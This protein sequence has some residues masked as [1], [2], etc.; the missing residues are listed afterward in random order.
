MR[1]ILAVSTFFFLAAQWRPAMD[2][3]IPVFADSFDTPLTFAENWAAYGNAVSGDGVLRLD[4]A[5]ATLRKKIPDNFTVKVDVALLDSD[6]PDNR[7]HAGLNIAEVRF[8][9]RPDGKAWLVYRLP[10]ETNARGSIRNIP[11]FKF[12]KNYTIT[13]Q[14]K[15]A[16]EERVFVFMLDGEDVGIAKMPLTAEAPVSLTTYRETALFDNFTLYE[17]E[18]RENPSPNV[19]VN[20]SFAH[21]QEGMPLYF[22]TQTL[23]KGSYKTTHE[24]FL[25]TF[26]V[27]TEEKRGGEQS[28][29][30]IFDDSCHS[31]GFLT[32]P[33]EMPVGK[34]LTFSAWLKSSEDDFPVTLLLYEAWEKTHSKEITVGRD[35]ARYS[36]TLDDPRRSTIRCGLRFLRPG[37][38]WVDEI[39]AESAPEPTPYRPSDLDDIKFRGETAARNRETREF[40]VGRL[41]KAPAAPEDLD[42]WKDGATKAETFH[43]ANGPAKAQSAAWLACDDAHLYIG[44]RAWV[45]DFGAIKAAGHPHDSFDAFNMDN[46]EIM[47]D[48]GRTRKTYF[49]LVVSAGGGRVDFGPGRAVAWDGDWQAAARLNPKEKSIDYG[50]KIPFGLLAGPMIDGDWGLNIGRTDSRTGEI[51]CLM[52]VNQPSF[53]MVQGYPVMKFPPEVLKRFALGIVDAGLAQSP[54]GRRMLSLSLDNNT[55]VPVSGAI[56]LARAENAAALGERIVAL[57]NGVNDIRFEMPPDIADPFAFYATFRS[58]ESSMLEQKVLPRRISP[59]TF[60][61]KYSYYMDDAQALFRVVCPLD[62]PEEYA[63]RLE[64]DGK[65]YPF[66]MA[67]EV[68][69]PVPLAD[70]SPGTHTAT[71]IIEKDG[72]VVVRESEP[73][74]KRPFRKGAARVNRFGRFVVMDDKPVLPVMPLVQGG[75]SPRAAHADVIDRLADSGFR[76]V[77]LIPRRGDREEALGLL[78][79][80]RERG[81]LVSYW[82]QFHWYADDEAVKSDVGM[83]NGFDNVFSQLVIDEPELYKTSEDAFAFIEKTRPYFPYQPVFMNNTILGIPNRFANLNTEILMLDDYITNREYR[84][85][86]EMIDQADIMWKAGEA[87]RR[88]FYFFLTGNN[89]HNHYREPTYAEQIAQTY[90]SL[91]AGCTGFAYFLGFASYPENWRAMK[92]L[93]RELNFLADV[94]LTDRETTPARVSDATIRHMTRLKGDDLYIIAVNA[95]D[96]PS[97]SVV[98]SLPD[99]RDYGEEVEALFDGRSI[100]LR[101]NQFS[102]SFPPLSRRVYRAAIRQAGAP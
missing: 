70:V 20:S 66:T 102:D 89:Q 90:G 101:G 79:R 62:H 55:G 33:S 75:E 3:G 6:D 31:Q 54:D 27:D 40:A 53:H 43:S 77:M 57:A 63:A 22:N 64:L 85:V 24:Q 81:L 71:L 92:E 15:V 95:T 94:V 42:A 46:I 12:G 99:G 23:R 87:E 11:D 69:V 37:T 50:V 4:R 96:V 60:Y 73:L 35:W 76:E 2:T 80:A 10:H 93:A 28:L 82:S 8:L 18:Q 36:F 52:P 5:T 67:G 100:N 83:I 56:R 14:M 58:A 1:K 97:D 16:G 17:I 26:A 25:K 49:H 84:T 13:A 32:Y 98:I 34:P 38:V 29:R 7:G 65:A 47:I 61:G 21:L 88:P 41:E 44:V 51:S 72:E 78:S 68:E 86:Q 91:V 74:V 19:V 9:I 30:L 48:P 39:Q 59:I 45:D